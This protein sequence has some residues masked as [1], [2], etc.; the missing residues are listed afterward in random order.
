MSQI[1]NI[2]V[3]FYDKAHLFVFYIIL[4]DLNVFLQSPL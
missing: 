4:R 2:F 1:G 3:R